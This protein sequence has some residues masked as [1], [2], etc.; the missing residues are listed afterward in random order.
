MMVRQGKERSPHKCGLYMDT[1]LIMLSWLPENELQIQ[2]LGIVSC[3]SCLTPFIWLPTFQGRNSWRSHQTS[4]WA[5]L[6]RRC[7]SLSSKW[8]G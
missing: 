4:P 6:E 5:L 7:F 3:K 2:I 1:L 8:G